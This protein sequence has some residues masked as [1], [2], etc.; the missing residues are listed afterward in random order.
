MDEA[1]MMEFL[2]GPGG[3]LQA[4]VRRPSRPTERVLVRL[5]PVK[6]TETEWEPTG[7]LYI[8]DLKPETLREL[9]LRRILLAVAASDALRKR[10]TAQL[11]Q[12]VPPVG[13]EAFDKLFES[14]FVIDEPEIELRRPSGRYL[15]EEFYGE[16]ARVYRV[17][18]ERG[19][20]PRKTIAEAAGVST[21]VAGRWVRE[22]RKRELLPATE[23]GK[24][25]A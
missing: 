11:K 6:G 3:W 1:R 16:V 19:M 10:L 18:V 8:A 23:P 13:S 14:G 5:R 2:E 15:P 21:E 12:H 24:V 17:A 22:A 20:K 7:E 4:L 25:R 9:P